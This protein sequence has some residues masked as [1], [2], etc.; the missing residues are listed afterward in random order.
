VRHFL[1]A[2]AVLLSFMAAPLAAQPAVTTLPVREHIEAMRHWRLG[3]DHM[4]A[5]QWDKAEAEFKAAVKL[6]PTLEM[7]HYGLGQVYMNTKRFPA[8]VT[9]YLGCRDAFVAN[10]A[11]LATND[12]AAQ[13]QLD[14]QIRVLEDERTLQASGRV[15]AMFSGGPADLD[16][17][18]SEMKASRF[19]GAKAM[20]GIPSWISIALGSAYFRSGAMADAEHEYRAALVAD[21][22]LGEAH[23]NLA[24]VCMLT[25]RYPEADDEI[26]AA[27]KA[28][29]KVNPQL[30][31]DLKSAS[32]RQ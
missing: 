32:A 1:A 11:R 12:L 3:Q 24:V 17:R 23:N 7:A 26:K 13:R 2:A 27:E 22:K 20:P 10:T 28:G 6:E 9:A 19:H 4:H 21:P 31:A 16:R 29:F 25:G 30:K 15:K 5:E 14:D 18:I 8:A